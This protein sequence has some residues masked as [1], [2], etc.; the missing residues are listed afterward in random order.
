LTD[1]AHAVLQSWY[2]GEVGGEALF[3]GLAQRAQPERARKWLALAQVEARVGRYLAETLL[4]RRHTLP[5][6]DTQPARARERCDAVAGKSWP[7]LMQWLE[8]I[9]C[10][11]LV[12]MRADAAL[13]P[14]DLRETG[15]YVLAHEQ[16]L[17]D[18][19][20][21]ELA[22]HGGAS[23]RPIETFLTAR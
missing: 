21:L 9:A 2:V 8:I 13:L 5:S 17:I 11:A 6:C 3:W 1:A 18:F 15:D 10:D 23:L 7:E 14:E 22:G 4:L 16:A 12:E 19:A 20:R